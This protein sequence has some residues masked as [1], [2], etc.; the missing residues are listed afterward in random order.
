MAPFIF[1]TLYIMSVCQETYE[2]D[3]SSRGQDVLFSRK[4]IGNE[5]EFL[6]QMG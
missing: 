5:N 2:K 4:Q 6:K 3:V 1:K